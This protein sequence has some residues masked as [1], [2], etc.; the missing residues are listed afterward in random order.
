MGQSGEA[1]GAPTTL[2]SNDLV[3]SRGMSNDER[4]NYTMSF[5]GIDKLGE[6]LRGDD[7]AG[8]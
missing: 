2:T 6:G 3:T 5:Y 1:A 8:L 4:L 7:T